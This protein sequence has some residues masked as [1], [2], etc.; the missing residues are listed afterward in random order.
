[1]KKNNQ[2]N[3]PLKNEGNTHFV[4][5]DDLFKEAEGIEKNEDFLAQKFLGIIGTSK[6]DKEEIMIKIRPDQLYNFFVRI[7]RE[8]LMGE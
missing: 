6:E 8:I 3:W 1:M 5:S 4:F 7:Q 2:I